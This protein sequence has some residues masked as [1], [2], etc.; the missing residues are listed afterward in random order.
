MSQQPQWQPTD[1]PV[2]PVRRK[3]WF[4][5]HKVLS[6][7][8]G[9]AL[10]CGGGV[11]ALGVGGATDEPTA[12]E[13]ARSSTGTTKEPAASTPAEPEMTT[14]Q[15]NAIAAGENY[16][17]LMPFSEQGLI[18]QLSSDAGDGYPKDVARAAVETLEVDFKEQAVQAAED[19]LDLMP[20]SRSELIQQLSSD[21]GDG[22]TTEQAE[23]AVDQVM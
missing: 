10:L 20:F 15:K 21:A 17:E 14:E 2:P 8:L 22:Y 1:P 18:E 7:V 19:Y 11:G 3:S 13:P 6:L 16:L 23:Y 5:R 4:A 12:Q 9:L